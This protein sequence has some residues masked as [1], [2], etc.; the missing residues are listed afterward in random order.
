VCDEGVRVCDDEGVRACD[1]EGGHVMM[2]EREG[3]DIYDG[4][5]DALV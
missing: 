3:E 4:V 1:D 5:K 2:R